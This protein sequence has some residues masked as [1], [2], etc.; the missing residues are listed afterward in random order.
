VSRD[1]FRCNSGNDAPIKLENGSVES[2]TS[3][4]VGFERGFGA[5]GRARGRAHEAGPQ[6][7]PDAW[8]LEPHVCRACFSR[9]VSCATET[10]TLADGP[11]LGVRRYQCTGCGVEALGRAPD[12]L[13]SCGLKIRKATRGGRS[14]VVLTDAGIRCTPNPE[15]RADFSQLFVAQEVGP[16]A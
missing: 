14:S 15:I 6:P 9:L 3:S 13:C 7:G 1:L 10:R 5:K 4:N 12:V 8:R 11:L 2:K 16:R